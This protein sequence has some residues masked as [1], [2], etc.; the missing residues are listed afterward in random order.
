MAIPNTIF[1]FT[2][3]FMGQLQTLVAAVTGPNSLSSTVQ[4]VIDEAEALTVEGYKADR[5]GLG[6][7]LQW[8]YVLRTYAEAV[9]G[10]LDRRA[11]LSPFPD[12]RNSMTTADKKWEA[13]LLLWLAQRVIADARMVDEMDLS[14]SGIWKSAG[15]AQWQALQGTARSV[16]AGAGNA[17]A[18]MANRIDA[19]YAGARLRPNGG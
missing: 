15:Q 7:L 12:E 13:R 8:A 14:W 6:P 5:L 1:E 10:P 2:D 11:L 4:A 17:E 19:A 18:D 3:P 16:I 9:R